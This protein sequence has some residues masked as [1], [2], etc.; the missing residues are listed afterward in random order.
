MVNTE[1]ENIKYELSEKEKEHIDLLKSLVSQLKEKGIHYVIAGGYGLDGLYGEVTRDH[2]DID[3]LVE[4]KDLDALDYVL[5]EMKFEKV[6]DDQWKREYK[7]SGDDFKIECSNPVALQKHGFGS[8]LTLFP[9][10]DNAMVEGFSFSVI[11]LSTVKELD[12]RQNER[13]RE[14]NWPEYPHSASKER[15][16]T[17]IEQQEV[18][19][20]IRESEE[21]QQ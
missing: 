14:N 21:N 5:K 3:M 17:Q 9:E 11:P 15:L 2:G 19:R 20:K 16:I 4:E 18:L 8:K 1:G 6:Q 12:S 10:K 13:A 7:R